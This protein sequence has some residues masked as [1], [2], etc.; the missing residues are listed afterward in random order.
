M[1]RAWREFGR[2]EGRSSLRTWLHR[3][4][5]NVCIDTLRKQSRRTVPMDLQPPTRAEG[6]QIPPPLNERTWVLPIP[7][8]KF[9]DGSADP[10]E[11]VVS[12]ETVRLAFVP[13]CSG[14]PRASARH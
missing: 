12:R 10:A 9:T 8:A 6:A 13:R 7:D 2:F 4:A 11:L 1:V 3:I 5:T 14:S